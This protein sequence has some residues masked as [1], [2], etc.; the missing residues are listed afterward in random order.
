M[1]IPFKLWNSRLL[2]L[3]ARNFR[4]RARLE[5]VHSGVLLQSLTYPLS[6]GA[7]SVETLLRENLSADLLGGLIA[8]SDLRDL[9]FGKVDF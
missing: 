2:S 5:R 7:L 3:T 1:I 6:L 8:E 4:V 9:P